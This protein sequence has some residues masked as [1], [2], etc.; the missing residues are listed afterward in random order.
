MFCPGNTRADEI[1]Y[2]CWS[3]YLR[4]P[5]SCTIKISRNELVNGHCAHVAPFP[6]G[7][8]SRKSKLEPSK[9]LLPLP[10]S[11]HPAFF[12]VLFQCAGFRLRHSVVPELAVLML[13]CSMKFDRLKREFQFRIQQESSQS[14]RA[15]GLRIHSKSRTHSEWKHTTDFLS[16]FDVA[17][18][19]NR[20]STPQSS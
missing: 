2:R 17:S 14:Q 12:V 20:P 9:L 1:G 5:F 10:C 6:P 16:S 13:N 19:R 11:L 18:Q 15:I 7:F 3:E 4:V 8:H